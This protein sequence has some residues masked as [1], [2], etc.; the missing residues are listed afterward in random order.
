MFSAPFDCLKAPPA[1][2]ERI[3]SFPEA[4]AIVE[5]C[6][7]QLLTT[8]T[9]GTEFVDLLSAAGRVLADEI[10]ADRDIPP[11]HRATRDGFVV[12]APDVAQATEAAPVL[13]HVVGETKAG[14]PQYSAAL[15]TGEALE[16]MTGAPVPSG[17]QHAVVM[18]EHT[19]R[20]ESELRVRGPVRA[21]E[22][23]VPA[24]SE[25]AQG[26]TLLRSGHRLDCA[27]IAMAA[28][29]G[30]S[31]LSVYAKPRIAILSTGDELVEID[32]TPQPYQ[33]RNSNSYSLAAQV[34]AAGGEPLRLPI[35][36]DDPSR[37]RELIAGGLKSD[38]LL[39]SGGVSMGKYD[40]VEQ[41]LAE[42]RAKPLF[43]GALIQ[44]GRPIVFG[45]VEATD[46]AERYFF[47]LPGNPVS[48]MVTFELFVRP[49]LEA[50]SGSAPRPLPL[51]QA[52]LRSE[53]KTKPGLTR[54]LPAHLDRSEVQTVPWHGSGD[55]VAVAQANCC[56][57]I[58]PDRNIFA[59]GDLIDVL[60][61][62]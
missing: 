39:I 15:K 62:G 8:R 29:E 12:L 50:L 34:T 49:M 52:R 21:G 10:E 3:V 32:V 23:I 13:L 45:K 11:F 48:T 43:T 61:R 19:A 58:P 40:F 4:R 24:G 57:V 36:P 53:I 25:A 27:A 14:A 38:L 35:A 56:V 51:V 1:H 59:A 20:S 16:I 28:G 31:Y 2:P 9:V 60:L 6:A 41:V 18:L 46:N 26:A 7:T 44:P 17:D 55:I 30:R 42:F 33:I 5:Q 54:F 47:G 22:N 37:L